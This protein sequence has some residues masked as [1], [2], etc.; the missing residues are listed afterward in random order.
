MPLEE[1]AQLFGDDPNTI[2]VLRA[3]DAA[4]SEEMADVNQGSESKSEGAQAPER[5]KN[6]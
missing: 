6:V 5:I 3:G 4:A 2:A 1:V